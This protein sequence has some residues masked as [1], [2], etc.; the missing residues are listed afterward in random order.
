M[1]LLSLCMYLAVLILSLEVLA[2]HKIVYLISPPRSLS[3]AFLRMIQTRGDFLI[4]HEPTMA[5]YCNVFS[6][7]FGEKTY[8][9]DAPKTFQEVEEKILKAADNCPVFVKEMSVSSREF[10]SDQPHFI[11]NVHVRFVFLI[12]NPHGMMISHY[13]KLNDITAGNLVDW[14]SYKE[15]MKI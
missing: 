15:L 1:K 5:A 11:E 6:K 3:T 8:K 9:K 2:H 14:F 4:L 13:K 10:F 7:E 12:R